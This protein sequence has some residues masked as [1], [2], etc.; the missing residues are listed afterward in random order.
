MYFLIQMKSE[1][2]IFNVL[3]LPALSGTIFWA[4]SRCSMMDTSS[5]P[6]FKYNI[7]K[8]FMLMLILSLFQKRRLPIQADLL[9][10][11]SSMLFLVAKE[12]FDYSFSA[13]H[14]IANCNPGPAQ[15]TDMWT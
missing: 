7:G 5:P 12:T 9:F 11:L 13:M 8:G 2:N 6:R 10:A 15:L 14:L 1:Y 4:W 3:P